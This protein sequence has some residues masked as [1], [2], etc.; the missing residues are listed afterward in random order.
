MDALLLLTYAALCIAA[1]KIFKIPLN[2]WTVPTAV[3]G[4]VVL[5]GS[6]ILLMNYN[7]PYS[8][9]GKQAYRTIPI[10]SQVRG[11][12]MEVP[13]KANVMLKKGDVLFT[14]DPTPFQARV[15]DL[16]AQVKAASQDALSLDSGLSEAKAQLNK[17]IAE[18]DQAQ[19]EYARYNEGHAKGAF[20]DQMVDTRRQ[21]YK[22]A[23]AT[24]V[25]A[26]ANVAYAQNSLDS[27]VNGQNTKV[28]SLL[29]QLRKAEFDLEN[30]V[31]RAPSAGYVSMVGLRPGTMST[32]LGLL[33]LMTFVPTDDNTELTFVAA[34]RQNS[35]QRLSEGYKAE[36]L[37]PG[38]PGTVFSGEVV[39][40]LPAIGES[41][42]QGQG[43]LLTTNTLSQ[44]GRV[45]VKVNATDERLKNYKL[46]QGTE[47]HIAIYSDHFKH[48]SI[49]RKI[50][51]R[52]KSWESY[53][54]LDH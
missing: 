3:L 17:A 15:D 36:L 47:V 7:F 30:T 44:Q 31:I 46:P 49:I 2:K 50:L 35:M 14:L 26:R 19:R 40:V 6:L 1:F 4:G 38:I 54:Y 48:V 43:T 5:V 34:F 20:S 39:E 13:V 25:A 22:A 41:Q 52:M 45:M 27:V 8:D 32:A 37:F 23:E 16:R 28:A 24:V 18:R 51:I 42:F 11:R 10:V 29:A 33:P 21:T 53:L 9:I 12:V